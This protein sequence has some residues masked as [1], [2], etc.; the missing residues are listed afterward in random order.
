MRRRRNFS[1]D[2][3]DVG[4]FGNVVGVVGLNDVYVVG[5]S[6]VIE[7]T[8]RRRFHVKILHFGCVQVDWMLVT[9]LLDDCCHFLGEQ[10]ME[11]LILKHYSY[12]FVRSH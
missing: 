6:E 5:L 10:V 12:I 9:L 11:D 8:N 4:T 2:V 1:G 3:D 7:G